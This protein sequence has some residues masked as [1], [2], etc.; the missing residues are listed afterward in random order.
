[1]KIPG[2]RDIKLFKYQASCIRLVSKRL[3]KK[4]DFHIIADEQGLGKTIEAIGICNMLGFD[5]VL[6]VC[7]LFVR[8]EW[9]RILN[10]HTNSS[11][12]LIQNRESLLGRG[13]FEIINYDRVRVLRD[14]LAERKYD[15]IICD[16]FQHVKNRKAKRTEALTSLEIPKKL[17]LSGTP[18]LNRT[19]EL[20][21]ILNY[22]NPT[23]YSDYY[24]FVERYS[25]IRTIPITTFKYGRYVT[26]Y[27]RKYVGG[28]NLSELRKKLKKVMI[29]RRKSD[30]LDLP[31]KMY[32]TLTVP[33]T[34]KQQEVYD[35]VVAD[36]SVKIGKEKISARGAL[37]KFN[38]LRQ[39]CCGLSAV[40]T[41][42]SSCKLN[43]LT[44][45]CEDYLYGDHK[46]FVVSPF[47]SIAQQAYERLKHYG[48]VYVDGTVSPMEARKR[49]MEFN[50]NKKCRLYIGTIGRNKEGLTLNAADYV[51]FLGKSLVQ[52][53]NEQVEDRVHRIGQQSSVTVVSIISKGSIDEKIEE[54]LLEKAKLFGELI[55]G[56]DL[57]KP[58]VSSL[59]DIR[60]ILR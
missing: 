35:R 56:V 53:I 5:R 22:G 4:T 27:I 55:D 42:S 59:E 15:C 10:E 21:T 16:E 54:L 3:K 25:K 36:L 19:E 1:M 33:M 57:S 2:F 13:R 24:A 32:Q 38:K 34:G 6:V 45:F 20:W 50:K 14:E 52:K 51:I 41:R 12:L 7:P 30:V 39:I 40:S 49:K 18:I 17:F 48:A 46:F 37:G 29:R 60:R 26:F 9:A 8:D 47:R 31:P 43:V 11:Y 44:K 28:K 58:V 23:R